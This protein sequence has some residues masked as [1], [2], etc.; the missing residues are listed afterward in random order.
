MLTDIARI[1]IIS[2]GSDGRVELP[3]SN[4]A[5]EGR[6]GGAGLSMHFLGTTRRTRTNQPKY[7]FLCIGPHDAQAR[8]AGSKTVRKE[9]VPEDL[10]SWRFRAEP[11]N[12]D[13][14]REQGPMYGYD[15]R[16]PQFTLGR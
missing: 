12:P 9:F 8:N 13:R 3:L 1:S 5:K 15:A 4:F 16:Q 6:V 7:E 11:I 10:G 14:W 2:F